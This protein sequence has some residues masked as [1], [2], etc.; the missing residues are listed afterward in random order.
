[1]QMVWAENIKREFF[2]KHVKVT[3]VSHA[4]ESEQYTFG[5][6]AVEWRN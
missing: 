4:H 2:W 1:M 5:P 3:F 6:G